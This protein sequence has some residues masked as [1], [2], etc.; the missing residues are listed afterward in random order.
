MCT[1]RRRM[2][3]ISRT[4]TPEYKGGYV[5]RIPFIPFHSNAAITKRQVGFC[6]CGSLTLAYRLFRVRSLG[7]VFLFL[8]WEC[9]PPFCRV[10]TNVTDNLPAPYRTVSYRTVPG[11]PARPSRTSEPHLWILL[12]HYLYYNYSGV[13]VLLYH[14]HHNSVSALC[15]HY[16]HIT[17]SSASCRCRY[18]RLQYTHPPL[19]SVLLTPYTIAHRSS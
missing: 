16:H 8:V 19:S 14:H 15:Y 12:H 4:T 10:G 3:L 7:Y 1:Q 18:L 2:V 11:T 13:V 9:F 5:L 6:T 17:H